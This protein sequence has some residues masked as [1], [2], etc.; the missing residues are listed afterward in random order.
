MDP[1]LLQF[2]TQEL[3]HV[4]DMGA[5]FAAR[6]P[7]IAS[8]L[9]M[10]ATEVQDP[11]VER[12]LEGFAFLTARVQLRLHEEFP[13]FTEQLLNRISVNFLAPVPA[14]GVVQLK[15]N[16]GDVAL[17]KGVPVPAGTV[18]QSQVA[19][20]VHTPC[21]FRTG[22]ALT[23]WPLEIQAVEHGP[24]RGTP[25]KVPGKGVVR[26]ALHIHI[27]TTTQSAL[28][29]L[30]VDT[31]DFHV[32]CGD[33]YAF[34]L[35]ERACYAT[36][37]V[38]IR[39]TGQS[40]WRFLP[41]GAVQAMGMSDEEALLPADARQFSGT[42]LLQEFFAFPQRFLF[43]Q[44]RGLKS[45]LASFQQQSFELALCFTDSNLEMDRV[46]DQDSLA[47]NCT[48]VVNLFE[49]ACDRVLLDERLHEMHV[50]PNRSRPQDFE[51]HSVLGVQGHGQHKLLSVPAL[52]SNGGVHGLD[53]PHYVLRRTPTLVSEKQAREGGRSSYSGT[54]VYLGLTQSTGELIAGHGLQQLAVRALCTNRDLP[55]LMPV[56]KGPTDL[57]WPGNLPLQSIRFL[58]GPS[59][60]KAPVK[61]AQ[62]CWQLIEHLSLNYLGLID[63]A[64]S[65]QQGG[66]AAITQLLGLHAAP[67]QPAQQHIV[68]AVQSVHSQV[69]VSRIVRQGK[70]AVVRGL[71]V[72]LT[73]DELALQ[74]LGVAVLG[75][76]LARYL[77]AHVSVNSFVQTRIRSVHSGAVLDCPAWSGN[78][79]LL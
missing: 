10:D 67:A 35:F 54:D 48:P 5:E 30:P 28:S 72:T 16:L 15:P 20:G 3:A 41:A 34:P 7:K 23:L 55:L 6:F 8:R 19:K 66:A 69:A 61:T 42:R 36:A 56:G 18:L 46:V 39:P 37:V 12:L 65:E 76:V 45:H 50:Q 26:S 59:R 29:Q 53:T 2:Y 13:R 74:G 38:A 60:P 52:Y 4:R 24:F 25:P 44:V 11:Y 57:V 78:R 75:S 47:L 31:L 62:T 73:L 64:S 68:R 79:P 1:R 71:Q 63:P 17:K 43:F 49:H 21:K 27:Q 51:V 40:A 9:A 22:H 58:R 33:E 32:S 77:A 14:M 70:P